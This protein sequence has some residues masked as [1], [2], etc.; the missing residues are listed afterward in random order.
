MRRIRKWSLNKLK[1]EY[2][3]CVYIGLFFS[4]GALVL[5][6]W[7]IF[8]D[9]NVDDR[10]YFIFAILVMFITAIFFGIEASH[11]KTILEIR[12]TK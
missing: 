11:I 1:K 7:N 10:L 4:A 5:V 8:A 6:L 2:N 3:E 9:T 12:T